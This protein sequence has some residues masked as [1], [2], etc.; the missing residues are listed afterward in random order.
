[1]LNGQDNYAI[2]PFAEHGYIIPKNTDAFTV[3]IWFYPESGPEPTEA[4]IILSQQNKGRGF[5][6]ACP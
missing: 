2:L 1:M 6:S 5:G 3:E 4:H